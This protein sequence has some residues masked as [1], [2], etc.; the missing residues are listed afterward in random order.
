VSPVD[1]VDR[2]AKSRVS[3]AARSLAK[4]AGDFGSW[5]INEVIGMMNPIKPLICSI[6]IV[7]AAITLA[8]RCW[9]LLYRVL[10]YLAVDSRRGVFGTT[11]HPQAVRR[12]VYVVFVAAVSVRCLSEGRSPGNVALV[13][14]IAAVGGLVGERRATGESRG[15]ASTASAPL[16]EPRCLRVLP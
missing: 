14:S 10:A 11:E 2:E 16:Q 5:S 3:A 8:T 9:A 15:R 13:V 6:A 4:S 12:L 1:R 7:M